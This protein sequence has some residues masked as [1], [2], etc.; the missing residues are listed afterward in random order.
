MSEDRKVAIMTE[1]RQVTIELEVDD[2]RARVTLTDPACPQPAHVDLDP[3][4]AIAIGSELLRWGRKWAPER[5]ERS[6]A[7]GSDQ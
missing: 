2:H 4:A 6:G 5:S 7:V 1:L 3:Q